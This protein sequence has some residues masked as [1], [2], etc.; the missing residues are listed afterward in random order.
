[1]KKYIFYRKNNDFD[2]PMAVKIK[3]NYKYGYIAQLSNLLDDIKEELK[4]VRAEKMWF[5]GEE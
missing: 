1:M 5:G 3:S 4:E 2:S